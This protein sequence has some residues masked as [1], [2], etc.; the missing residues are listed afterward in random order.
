M[1]PALRLPTNLPPSP[2][3]SAHRAAHR[4]RGGQR[5][6]R[7]RPARG[8]R[9]GRRPRQVVGHPARRGG[10]TRARSLSCHPAR[11]GRDA[12]R[13]GRRSGGAAL[14]GGRG[15]GRPGV[16]QA[17]FGGGRRSFYWGLRPGGAREGA[18][19]V[20]GVG[21]AAR[22]HRHPTPP[23]SLLSAPRS[24]SPQPMAPPSLWSPC[25]PRARTRTPRTGG[26]VRRSTRHAARS[27]RPSSRR[28][29]RRERGT[30]GVV[31]S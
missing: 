1:T 26:A 16:A 30:R 22:L 3:L 18:G 10:Q 7:R 6:V 9:R 14:R 13:V 28:S 29:T 12:G 15:G 21:R 27:G 20:F 19:A 23:L 2:P 24:T 25:W 11:R 31:C 4:G 5:R 8:G 17:L